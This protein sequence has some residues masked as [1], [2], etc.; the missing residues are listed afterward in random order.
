MTLD[1]REFLH[2]LGLTGAAALG[3]G[4][5]CRGRTGGAALDFEGSIVGDA[6]GPCHRELKEGLV[7]PG[8]L[9]PV[10]ADEPLRDVVIVGGGLSGLAAAWALGRHG[11]SD[12]VLLE[13]ADV[14]GGVARDGRLAGRPCPWGAHYL[15]LP[16]ARSAVLMHLLGDVG[17]IERIDGQGRPVVAPR[18]RVRDPVVNHFHGRSHSL[19]F[20][21]NGLAT[22]EDHAAHRA[23]DADMDRWSRLRDATGEPAFRLPISGRGRVEEAEALDRITFAAYLDGRGLRSPVLR[24]FVDQ[25]LTDEYGSRAGEISA[26]AAVLYWAAEE[27][28]RTAGGGATSREAYVSWPEGNGFLVRG[29]ARYL[30]PGAARL[31]TRVLEVREVDGEV[32]VLAQVAGETAVRGFRGRTCLYAAPK[33]GA[34]AILP[35]LPR[36]TRQVLDGLTYTPWLVAN[37]LLAETPEHDAA[38]LA[39]DNLITPSWSLGFVNGQHFETPGRDA[40]A[41]FVL[42]FYA[43]FAG[44]LRDRARRDLL[45]LDWE[46]WASLIVA[47]LELAMPEVRPQVRQ[48]D[49]FRW[50]H[51]MVRPTPGCLFG[52][53]REAL[54]APQGRVLLAANDAHVLPLYEEAVDRGV[55][56]AEQAL[57]RLGRSYCSLRGILDAPEVR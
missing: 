46:T 28:R 1:R 48:L 11:V 31:G 4:A 16:D 33:L 37:L 50:G 23:F 10:E 15:G 25:R 51:A 40:E 14:L 26:Y 34:S 18:Y 13:R 44:A 21:P 5:G 53:P 35:E 38:C 7:P 19:G 9:G 17:V 41:P 29:L 12:L 43:A 52:G 20:F 54:S 30:P 47:E 45:A 27:G 56:A 57:D 6:P 3:D 39:W 22:A 42:T 36:A 24:D 55:A 8:P 2:L 49:L 32:R